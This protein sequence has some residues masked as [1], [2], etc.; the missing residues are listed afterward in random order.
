MAYSQCPK[1]GGNAVGLV[2]KSR[3][4][5]GPYHLAQFLC[6]DCGYGSRDFRVKPT[7]D[8]AKKMSDGSVLEA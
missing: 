4:K 6:Q 1:C 7:N 3:I 5:K 2:V 8:I